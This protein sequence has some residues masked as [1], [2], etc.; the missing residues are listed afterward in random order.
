M[1]SYFPTE[2]CD[3][4][5]ES[6]PPQRENSFQRPSHMFELKGKCIR[7]SHKMCSC[8][9]KTTYAIKAVYK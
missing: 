3:L 6:K 1:A 9:L 2:S 7:Y 5:A 8:L 4:G